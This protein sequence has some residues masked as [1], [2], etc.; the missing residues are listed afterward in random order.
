MNNLRI[1]AMV[2]ALVAAPLALAHHSAVQYDFTKL[3]EIK[4]TVK[5]FTA[6]NPHMRM[7]IEVKNPNGAGVHE[8]KLEGHST[9]NMYRN[10]YRKGMVNAG[11]AISVNVAPL[12]NGDEGGYVLG[13]TAAN[14]DYF[15]VRSTRS[16]DAAKA[17]E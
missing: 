10:G 17:K 6:V 14:G 13:A 15:G 8:V 16:L 5:Q 9:N 1:V 12:R 7:T 11:D 2:A 3:V 4:G